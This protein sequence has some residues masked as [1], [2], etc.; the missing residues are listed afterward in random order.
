MMRRQEELTAQ[1]S[2][3]LASIKN[4]SEVTNNLDHSVKMY[5]GEIFENTKTLARIA[6]KFERDGEKT[7]DE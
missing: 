5:L 6:S 3:M 2:A 1:D 7:R 4:F